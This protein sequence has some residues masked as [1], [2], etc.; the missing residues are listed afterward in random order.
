VL[1]QSP[2]RWWEVPLVDFLE[3]GEPSSSMDKYN[4]SF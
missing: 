3:Y 1:T 2:F 4:I